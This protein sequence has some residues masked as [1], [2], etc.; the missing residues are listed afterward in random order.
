[1]KSILLKNNPSRMDEKLSWITHPAIDRKWLA[2][3]LYG[4]TS[5]GIRSKLSKKI[6]NKLTWLPEEIE[7]L[8]EIKLILNKAFSNN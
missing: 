7:K 2:L 6:R 1:M 8:N 4:Y 5:D 3:Q